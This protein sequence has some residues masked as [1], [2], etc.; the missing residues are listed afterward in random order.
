MKTPDFVKKQICSP[1]AGSKWAGKMVL[2]PAMIADKDDPDTFYMLFRATGPCPE[3]RIEGKPMPYPIF[4]GYAVSHDRGMN[5]DF[6]FSRPALPLALKYGREEIYTVNAKGEKVFNYAN[7]GTE[8]P[9]LFYFE[10]ELYLT[11]A[12][13]TFP[14]GPY[15]DHDDPVQCMPD[16][17]KDSNFG[18]AVKENYTVTLLYKVDIDALKNK[19]YENA[20]ALITP[21]HDPDTSDDRDVILF[22]RRIEI[23]GRKKIVCIHRPK[24]PWQ[25][26]IGK[27]L[28]AS[29]SP[30]NAAFNAAN[31]VAAVVASTY[32]V[33]KPLGSGHEVIWTGNEISRNTRPTN[34]GLNRFCPSPPKLIFATPIATNAPITT[35]HQ[36][37]LLGKLNARSKPVSTAERSQMVDFCFKINFAISHSNSTQATTLIAV[38]MSAPIPNAKILT[39]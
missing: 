5:W 24:F 23:N 22:P 15:W 25:Y 1:A 32:A 8:D 31:G 20:F 38:V 39:T 21:L 9:R 33:S 16:W 30:P 27:E 19:D 11:V 6:D 12:A 17:V 26:E 37:K 29:A 18:R 7:G 35:I 28:T 4:I 36:G 2:N 10:D 13:R 34:A 14:P 3:A